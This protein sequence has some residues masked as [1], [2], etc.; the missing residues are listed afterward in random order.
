[1]VRLHPSDIADIGLKSSTKGTRELWSNKLRLHY[2]TAMAYQ[3]KHNYTYQ[4][5]HTI[6][7]LSVLTEESRLGQQFSQ[8]GMSVI[9]H[10]TVIKNNTYFTVSIGENNLRYLTRWYPSHLDLL[11]QA[12]LRLSCQAPENPQIP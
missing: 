3:P 4:R 5:V 9:I 7:Q 8:P 6:T 10:K 1:M 12:P 2:K 11:S